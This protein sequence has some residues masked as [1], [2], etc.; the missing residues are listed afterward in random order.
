MSQNTVSLKQIKKNLDRN[1][2]NI[3]QERLKHQLN[4]I[5]FHLFDDT[6]II[7]IEG[8]VTCSEKLLQK[9]DGIL[10]ARQVRK[11]IDRVIQPQIESAIEQVMNVRVIDFL[12]DTTIDNNCSFAIAILDTSKSEGF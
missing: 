7:F 11:A 4:K 5:S 6:L 3:Y 2:R 9:N 10:L 1:I 12:S 8:T